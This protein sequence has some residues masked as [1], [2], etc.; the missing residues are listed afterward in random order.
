MI[1]KIKVLPKTMKISRNKIFPTFDFLFLKIEKT[2]EQYMTESDESRLS[3][4]RE[5]Q[6]RLIDVFLEESKRIRSI[7]GVDIKT[8]KYVRSKMSAILD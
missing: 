3:D 6:D 7:E 2:K 4:I 5:H 1:K 8:L